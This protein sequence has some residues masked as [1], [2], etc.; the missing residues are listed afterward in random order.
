MFG[1][2]M[3]QP[4]L[5]SSL[6]RHAERHHGDARI[7]SKRVEGDLHR[8]TYLDFATRC[9]RLAN[10]LAALGTSAG[11]VVGTLAW[12]GHRHMELYHAVSGSGAVLHTLNPRLLPEQI[13]WIADHARDEVLFFDLTFLPLVEA[14]ATRLKTVKT[15]VLMTDRAHMPASSGI[16]NLQCYEDLLAGV[17]SAF[18][19]PV[20]DENTASSLCYTSGTT[21]PPKGVLYS[22]RSTLLHSF[23]VALPDAMGCSARDVILPV[24]PMFHANAWGLPY[25]ACLVGASLVLPGP[26]LDGK[27][28][29]E[30]FEGEGVT[31]ASG[32]PTIWQG[33]LSHVRAQ[34]LR[35]STLK[36]TGIGGSACPP[37]MIREFQHE[38]G[39]EVMHGWGMTETSP[40]ATGGTLKGVNAHLAGDER[41]ALQAKQGRAM[42]GVDM[43]VVDPD[44]QELPWDG[45]SFG[46]LMVRGPWIVERYL[47]MADADSPLVDGWF[48]SG[49]VATI[50]ADGYMRITDRAKDVIKSGGEWISSIEL[51]N[52]AVGHPA[53]A[54]AACIAKTDPKW[55]E[56]PLLVVVRKPGATVTRDEVMR[57]FDGK[58]AKWAVPDD[59]VFVESIPLGP[60]GKMQ[61]NQLRAAHA[62]LFSTSSSS[63]PAGP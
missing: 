63:P 52:I 1:Q 46:E 42:F 36:R 32:V 18:E 51:E 20:F 58:V 21:G 14:V 55:G 6:L 26:H 17:D 2:M 37:S 48:P 16:A 59:V 12:N 39:V 33:L 5:I 57:L 41:I 25:V 11:S 53:V 4:L 27:S 10:A 30:L 24:V 49:D 45:S 44:G 19:W 60:T 23:A 9:R 62:G 61:K 15:F 47:G 29:F 35:F 43:K 8:I 31:I 34:G 22:H 38:H 54:M 13:A 7:V 50:D 28:L 40:L 3:Q 56:R